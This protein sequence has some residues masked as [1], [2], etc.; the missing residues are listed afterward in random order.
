VSHCSEIL[1]MLET[2]P[3][4]AAEL[5][6]GV[7]C[8]VHSRISELRARGHEIVCEK[9]PGGR[10]PEAFVYT[11]IG[12]LT[13][14][15]A[16]DAAA[17]SLSDTGATPGCESVGD[18]EGAGQLQTCGSFTAVRGSNPVVVRDPGVAHL[19]GSE[20]TG[21]QPLDG[22]TPSLDQVPSCWTDSSQLS[23]LEAA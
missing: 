21:A 17:S 3:K 1:A 7:Y 8:I 22:T 19:L 14:L 11:L 20:E 6:R 9:V 15:A 23:L 5:H 4:S 10:G 16:P 12:S 18:N 2:G 13:E